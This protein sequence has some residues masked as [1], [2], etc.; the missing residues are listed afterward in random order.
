MALSER[1]MDSSQLLNSVVSRTKE[2]NYLP[3][4]SK[5][6]V[7]SVDIIVEASNTSIINIPK[8]TKFYGTNKNGSKTFSIN[9]AISARS[10]NGYFLFANTEIFEGYYINETF[11]VN[12]E[13]EDQ[14]F[15]LS[16]DT[17]DLDSL[18]V[19]VID[20]NGANGS[21]YTK[22]TNLYAL[23]SNS[24]VY[25]LQASQ[26]GKYQIIFG[27]GI[28]GKKL[29]DNSTILTSYRVTTGT[30]GDDVDTFSM[31]N[32]LSAYN[33]GTINNIT[34]NTVESSSGGA[35]AEDI[36]SIKYNAPRHYQTQDRAV[37]N[38]DYIS[39]IKENFAYVKDVYVYGGETVT[40]SV[41][42]GK[43]FVCVTSYTNSTISDNRKSDIYNFI[44]TKNIRSITPVITDPDYI[45]IGLSL[46]IHTD[47]SKSVLTPS[48]LTTMVQSSIDDFNTNNL[49]AFN[50]EFRYS[51]FGAAIDDTD[52]SIL[53]NETK[54]FMIKNANINL[55]KPTSIT[56]N[57]NNA[58]EKGITSS[59]FIMNSKKYIMTDTIPEGNNVNSIYLF[60]INNVGKT[61]NYSKIGIIDY[62]K[63]LIS[64][65]NITISDYAGNGGLSFFAT[66]VNNDIYTYNNDIIEIDN[67]YVT[68]EIIPE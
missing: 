44:K 47:F 67:K 58:I 49:Q 3:R 57:Y 66:P 11:S 61:L 32:D 15:E 33:T 40:D 26:D 39:I 20:N 42:S 36:N 16:N 54:I 21:I 24:E 56:I 68:I 43:V 60:E 25:F 14:T 6:S 53:S 8:G 45:R 28:L 12:Y 37:I 31:S 1:F 18:I 22:K 19:S 27:D 9:E 62:D 55:Y 38:D 2:L 5:S 23:N 4:S 7:G 34:I 29:L 63:G 48:I 17:I 59:S 50:T 35:D 30:L 52:D 46:K 41:Q 64:I 10:S 51:K 13:I 65:G